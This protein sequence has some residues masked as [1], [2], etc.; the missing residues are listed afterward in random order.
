MRASGRITAATR[1]DDQDP[2]AALTRRI[3]AALNR[4]AMVVFPRGHH[5]LRS[6]AALR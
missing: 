2:A 3:R 1:D 6:G 4:V 5:H